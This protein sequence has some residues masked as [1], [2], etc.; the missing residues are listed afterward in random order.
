MVKMIFSKGFSS[1]KFL[2][3][4]EDFIEF[5]SRGPFDKKITLIQVI[6]A[7]HQRRDRPS[8]EPMMAKFYNV[9]SYH[10]STIIQMLITFKFGWCLT[11]TIAKVPV[12]VLW[13]EISKHQSRTLN[14]FET[15]ISHTQHFT[16]SYDET[17]CGILK[18]ASGS[19]W[20]PGMERRVA[21]YVVLSVFLLTVCVSLT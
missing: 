15:P 1:V 7:W 2:H 14:I 8:P 13:L 4:D 16:R 9:R 19:V 10:K 11:N 17:F 6:F 12:K 3:L 21:L 18:Y 5:C 20:D